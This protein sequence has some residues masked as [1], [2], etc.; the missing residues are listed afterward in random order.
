MLRCLVVVA[1]AITALVAAPATAAS[2]TARRDTWVGQVVRH[3]RH[4]DYRGSSCPQGTEACILV[5][6]N[7][8]IVPLTAEAA[9][10]LRRVAGRRAKLVGYQGPATNAN[11]TGTLY[12]RRVE[13]A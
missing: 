3:H 4:F 13:R 12:V 6:A 8:R 1:F 10:R 5:L 9:D 7:F 11:H 2:P